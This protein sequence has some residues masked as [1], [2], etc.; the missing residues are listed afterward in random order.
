MKPIRW[1]RVALGVVV[2][3]ALVW[4]VL[5]VVV[6]HLRVARELEGGVHADAV[7]VETLRSFPSAPGAWQRV[8]VGNVV[9][10]APLAEPAPEACAADRGHCFLQLEGG[11]LNVFMRGHLEPYEQMVN[12]RAPDERDLSMFRSAVANWET[13]DAL[14]LRALTSRGG[15]ESFRFESDGAKGVVATTVRDGNRRFLVAAYSLDGR[16]ARGIGVAGLPA[17][18]LHAIL[19]SVE[20]TALP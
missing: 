18:A 11:T 2:L 3:S 15:L 9:F 4:H 12:F 14:R 7:R 6:W 20:F 8:E 16:Q 19:G 5:P 1:L 13:I 10:D 17:E